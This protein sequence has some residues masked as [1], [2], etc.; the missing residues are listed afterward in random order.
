MTPDPAGERSL[1][2]FLAA[3]LE[4]IEHA[5]L[6]RRLAVLT[7]PQQVRVVRE[8]TPLV[9]FS[10][11]DYLGLASHPALQEAA[12]EEWTRGG[13]GSG[14]SRLLCGSLA[15]HEELEAALAAFK[16]TPAALCFSSGYAAALGAIPALCGSGDVILLDKLSHACLVD[17]ARLSGANLRVFPHNDLN[18][19]ESH[20]LWAAKKYPGARVLVVAESVY[21][22]DGDTAPLGGIVELKERHG[23]WLFL[24]EAHAVGV[25]GP[26]GR[27][28]AAQLGLSGR[29]DVQMGTLGKALGAHGAYVA[30][31]A[32][33]R[34]FLINRARSF[35]FSTAPPAPVAAAARRAVEIAQSPQ[36]DALRASLWNNI[37]QLEQALKREQG[38]SAILPVLIGAESAAMDASARL[39]DA[40]F[41]VPAIRYPTVAKGAARLRIT[42]TASHTESD[43]AALA[44][45]L[46]A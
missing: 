45:A 20:L 42:L 18:K 28:L 14:S 22:M 25:L 33:L 4:A 35:I 16:C 34:D 7:S 30:G 8:S 41:L 12:M 31:S 39:F 26:Q 38:P 27:G 11:N 15:A 5:G 29:V 32:T 37:R 24:D 2:R 40:G 46:L 23:A 9:N 17:A 21:S 19:L 6:R 10:S 44:Q 43:I 36:G 13:F 3:R 1:E